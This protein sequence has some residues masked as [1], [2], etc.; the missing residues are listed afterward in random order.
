MY[1]NKVTSSMFGVDVNEFKDDPIMGRGRYRQT[2]QKIGEIEIQFHKHEK[3]WNLQKKTSNMNLLKKIP[4]R[5]LRKR[6]LKDISTIPKKYFIKNPDSKYE[7]WMNSIIYRAKNRELEDGVVYEMHHIVPVCLG[8]TNDE[9]NGVALTCREHALVHKLLV[10]IYPNCPGLV[11]ALKA[12]MMYPSNRK[13]QKSFSS[14]EIGYY[15]EKAA[16]ANSIIMT[17]KKASK[18]ARENMSKARKGKKFSEEHKR[19]IGLAQ[20][21]FIEMYGSPNLGKKHSQETKDKIGQSH[22]HM[23]FSD[24]AKKN[25]SM[26]KIGQKKSDEAKKK[27]SESLRN[28]TKVRDADGNIFPNMNACAKYYGVS[29]TTIKR[30]VDDPNNEKFIGYKD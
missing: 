26:A 15:R 27:T 7:K 10:E 22:L 23:K 11:I 29:R 9:E 25:I 1:S 28:P 30:W 4:M 5:K 13:G 14:R 8:G 12:L 18:E 21:K 24:K 6:E 17:G 2:G 16:K 20:R 19:N 3:Y